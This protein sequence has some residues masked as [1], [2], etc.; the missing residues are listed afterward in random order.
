MKKLCK[1]KFLEYIE[2]N[3]S[4]HLSAYMKGYSAQT[5]L[6]SM[7]EKWR[8]LIFKNKFAGGTLID[9]RKSLIQQI[10]NFY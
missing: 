6:I 1:N 2:K 4:S 9:L 10:T 3:L 5:T 7:S 8:L